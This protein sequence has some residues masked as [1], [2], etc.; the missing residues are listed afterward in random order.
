MARF[1]GRDIIFDNSDKLILDDAEI[2]KEDD[3]VKIINQNVTHD[4]SLVDKEY[5]DTVPS[6]KNAI[7]NGCFRIWQR[8]LSQTT[9]GYGS[10]DRWN[11]SVGADAAIN[12]SLGTH[13]VGEERGGSWYFSRTAVT[14]GTIV[15]SY[16]V[17]IQRIENVS[18]FA[19]QTVT[20]SFDAKADATKPIAVEFYQNFGSGG[21]AVVDGLSVTTF[22]LTTGWVRYSVTVS[23]PS[24]TGKTVGA[25]SFLAVYFWFEG[26]SNY[27]TR[28]NSL[29]HQSG[30]FDICSV[31]LEEGSVAT[32]FENR[33]V[34]EEILL[35]QRYYE[36]FTDIYSVG[37]CIS[38][39]VAYGWLQYK[40]KKRT[41]PTIVIS[42]T[43]N[44][45]VHTPSGGTLN[46]SSSASVVSRS[47]AV[48]FSVTRA[49]AGLT[50]G[51][52]TLITIPTDS[53]ISADAEL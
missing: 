35:C 21:S 22:N 46:I 14:A 23:V 5:V 11:N 53:F 18:T 27:N 16:V 32:S 31:Q 40:V 15:S 4:E 34:G 9:L 50:A 29:G 13:T 6:R 24:I 8:A 30:T 33:H 17:K 47:Q 26:G 42:F 52:V 36:K 38:T 2:Y 39:T 25:G 20:L 44:T 45:T 7:I 43:T 28:N 49:L 41:T 37:Y 12:H 51:F 3:T 19:G 1:K 48:I 10:D